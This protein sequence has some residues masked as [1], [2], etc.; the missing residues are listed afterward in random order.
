[1]RAELLA[2]GCERERTGPKGERLG[3]TLTVRGV[4]APCQAGRC[5]TPEGARV[6]LRVRDDACVTAFAQRADHE[7]L[8]NGPFMETGCFQPPFG[9]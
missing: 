2:P 7:V 4:D 5:V 1:M 3:G 9:R 8:P 6:G